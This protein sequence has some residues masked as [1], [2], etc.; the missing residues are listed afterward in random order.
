MTIDPKLE[1][2][3]N[4]LIGENFR[5]LL[6][7]KDITKYKLCKEL[8][9]SYRTIINWQNGSYFPSDENAI[10]VGQ[11]LGL[12]TA[13]ETE[14]MAIRNLVHEINDRLKRLENKQQEV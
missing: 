6:K 4:Q 9:I 1:S 3:K 12:I 13:P 10:I 5:R 14:I 2:I 8:N 7:D 11:Y